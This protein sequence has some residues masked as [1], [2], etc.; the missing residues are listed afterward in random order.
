MNL[1]DVVEKRGCLY[2]FRHFGT[3]AAYPKRVK[4]RRRFAFHM[5]RVVSQRYNFRRPHGIGVG[6]VSVSDRLA[7]VALNLDGFH[8][9]PVRDVPPP[10]FRIAARAGVQHDRHAGAD[11]AEADFLPTPNHEVPSPKRP[12]R[13]RRLAG[14]GSR[15]LLEIAN[16]NADQ[17]VSAR[18]ALSQKTLG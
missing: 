6:F 8:D 1:A 3:A 2:G 10:V 17:F 16:W 7:L 18:R 4:N 15:V 13:L 9:A 12:R 5:A 11:F 14:F